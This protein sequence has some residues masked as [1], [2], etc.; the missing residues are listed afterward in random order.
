[1]RKTITTILVWIACLTCTAQ[2]GETV[3]E[4]DMAAYMM[5]YH[6]D[7][8][9]SLHAA[10]SRDGHTFTALNNGDPIMAGDTIA[11]QK[12]IR[13]PHIY[14][15]PDGAFYLAMTDLHIYAKRE[16]YRTTEWERDKALY[17]WG[18]NRALVL[19]KSRDLIHWTRANVRID[20]LAPSLAGIGCAWAPATAYDYEK[21]KL[22]IYFT[23]RYGTGMDKLYYCY[24]NDAFDRIETLPEVLFTYPKDRVSA[25]DG[26]I[27]YADGIYHLFYCSHDGTPGIKQATS[28]NITGP[29]TYSP[30]FCD[31]EKVK[32]EAPN[33]YKLIG[34]DKW[35]LMYDI[36]G[37]RPQNFGFSETS[38]FKTFH[39]LGHFDSG[40]MRRTNFSGQK[41]GAV[42]W[43]TK[44]EADRIEKYWNKNPH[45]SNKDNK[46]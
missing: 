19:M 9:H 36:Y 15:G 40:V 7:D 31:P 1:M 8:T 18:N 24:V 26:D 17:G 20:R 3:T 35:I 32:C 23:M 22:M 28:R 29:W 27:T 16:G 44:D 34:K 25:I 12:G 38:D 30:D 10:I 14:R 46:Q 42:V 4:K 13:D 45:A 33:V 5:V 41:H 2:T 43:L 21:K 11:T 39:D 6:R 37:A